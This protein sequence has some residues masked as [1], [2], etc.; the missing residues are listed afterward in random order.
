MKYYNSRDDSRLLCFSRVFWICE[1]AAIIA[2]AAVINGPLSAA[3]NQS[4]PDGGQVGSSI[5]TRCK[6]DL[7]KRLEIKLEDIKTISAQSVV[8]PNSALG[9][10][11][12]GKLYAQMLTPGFRVILGVRN[13]QYLYTASAKTC[14]YGG[15]VS[16]WSYSMLLVKPVQNDPNLNGDLYQCS[17]LGTNCTHLASKVAEPYPQDKGIVL[18]KRRTSRSS[19]DLLYINVKEPGKEKMLCHAFDFGAAAYDSTK[20][21][22]AVFVRSRLAFEWH[23]VWGHINQPASKAVTLPLPEGVEPSGITWSG[24]K[25]MILTNKD[26][27]N[28]AFETTPGTEASAWK[29]VNLLSY[30][31]QDAYMLS[32]SETLVIEAVSEGGKPGVEV[33]RVWFTGDRNVVSKISDFTLRGYDLIGPFAF[34]WGDRGDVSVAYTVNIATG[35]SILAAPKS[36][37]SIRPFSYPP[38]S[39]PLAAR[40]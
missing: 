33:A 9:M 17:L 19:F 26:D 8:W 14:K 22:W 6:D 32:K 1:L 30:P 15:P 4:T 10:P 31:G 25:L 12:M 11:E 38:I 29:P 21:R 18:F 27:R 23:V 16:I 34:I 5:V 36:G 40:K 37:Q 7:A 3:A 35:E 20:N 13:T 39:S 2:F 28:V 24:D